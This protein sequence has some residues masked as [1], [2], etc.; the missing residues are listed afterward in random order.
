MIRPI[1]RALLANGISFK[2]FDGVCR[3]AFVGVASEEFGVRGRATNTSRI[4]AMTGLSRKEVQRLRDPTEPNEKSTAS[5]LSPLAD[6]LH[7]WATGTSYADGQGQPA[8]LSISGS[9]ELSF[10]SLVQE[11]IG[12]VPPGAVRQELIRLGV[13]EQ[14]PDGRLSLVRRTLIPLDVATRLESAFIY[15]LHGL[16]ETIAHNVDPRT[17]DH[18]RRFERYVE[19]PPLSDPEIAELNSVLTELLT[20]VS[21]RID[22]LLSRSSSHPAKPSGH[23]IG[24]G[25]FYSE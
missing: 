7:V 14:T 25:I 20:D 22:E 23:R 19:S 9:G 17:P 4:S 10:E 16:A 11:C 21:E 2:E 24:V 8:S 15:S 5:V 3:Q 6:L 18:K 12:D 1:A 13:V